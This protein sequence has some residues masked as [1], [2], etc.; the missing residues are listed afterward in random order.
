MGV[1]FLGFSNDH[2]VRSFFLVLISECLILRCRYQQFICTRQ[3]LL[4]SQHSTLADTNPAEVTFYDPLLSS[5]K[6]KCDQA[7]TFICKF[8]TPEDLASDRLERMLIFLRTFSSKMLRFAAVQAGYND[9]QFMSRLQLSLFGRAF[10]AASCSTSPKTRHESP[11]Y[12]VESQ[13][14]PSRY[15]RKTGTSANVSS[16]SLCSNSP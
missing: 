2:D 12:L 10:S 11:S 1:P 4:S 7:S 5:S 3:T 8:L 13:G 16:S 9:Q 15:L 14:R 6:P